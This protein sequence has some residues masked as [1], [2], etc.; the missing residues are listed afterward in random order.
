MERIGVQEPIAG[1]VYQ[2]KSRLKRYVEAGILTNET[3]VSAFRAAAK[4]FPSR[5]ALS[6]GVTN[7]SYRELDQAT[8]RLAAALLR[9]GLAPKDPVLFQLPNNREVVIA[10]IACLKAGLIPICTLLAHRK[11]EIGQIGRQ[12]GAR[13]HIVP[14]DDPRFDFLDFSMQMRREVPS[15]DITIAVGGRNDPE[16]RV[17]DLD[18]LIAGITDEDAAQELSAIAL[19]PFQVAFY[20][21]SG[22][23][24]NVPKIIPRFHNEYLYSMRSVVAFHGLD[25]TTVAYTPSPMMHN[26]PVLC[27]WGPALFF[28]GEVVVCPSLDAVAIGPV[29]AARK[30]NWMIFPPA[31]LFRLKE[32]EWFARCDFAKAKGFLVT[33]GAEKFSA[34]VDGGAAWPLFGMTEGLV[35]FCNA[36]DSAEARNTTVG[37]PASPFDE[38]KIIDPDSGHEVA[39]GEV[40]EFAV[41]GPSA[42]SGY[43][44][45][46]ERNREVFTSDGFYRSGDLMKV[47]T[48]AGR[49]YLVFE[50]RLKDVVSRGGEKI[51]C[52][53]VE[54]VAI[55]HPAIGAI[56][57]VAMPD[58]VYGE[59]ACAFVIPVGSQRVSVAELGTFLGDKGLAKFKWPERIEFVA[60]FPLT[61]SG[62]LSK[63][64]LRELAASLVERA[65]S[66]AAQ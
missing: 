8:D 50:G 21:L 33:S 3:L 20:Q 30:P 34:L 15:L 60:D 25:E 17:H 58:G 62:K 13:A 59:R 42:I 46:E 40:G 22:G 49:D 16:K 11:I 66:A 54:N 36:S 53:E 32:S 19:D 41:R 38:I 2:D 57:I 64:Q 51:N 9:L 24:T 14:A 31:I 6:D 65:S 10:T 61:S 5:T 39:K 47:Q 7:S 56:A 12:A 4:R 55:D 48:V 1:V 35:A 45:S 28:G 52:A 37:R 29:L 43:F 63:P 26:A 18:A 44:D 23:T 27:V